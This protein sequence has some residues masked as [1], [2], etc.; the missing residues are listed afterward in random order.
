MEQ[1]QQ[2]LNQEENQTPLLTNS[3]NSTVE[4]PRVSSLNL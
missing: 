2:M 1:L 4:S 3:Q